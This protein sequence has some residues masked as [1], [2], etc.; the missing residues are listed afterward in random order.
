MHLEFYWWTKGVQKF[1]QWISVDLFEF[2]NR[3]GVEVMGAYRDFTNQ[4]W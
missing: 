3:T 2:T 4:P 1:I